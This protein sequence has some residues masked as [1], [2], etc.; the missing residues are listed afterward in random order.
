M[1]KRAP[2][3]GFERGLH[4]EVANIIRNRSR[5]LGGDG[6]GRSGDGVASGGSGSTVR[7]CGCG[8]ARERERSSEERPH[9]HAKLPECL[10]VGEERRSSGMASSQSF[11]TATVMGAR[12]A[13]VFSGES[14]GCGLG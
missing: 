5:G 13:R 12:D 7:P 1:R 2:G 6:A 10:F 11:S 14:G 4:W 9:H 8:E 3:L